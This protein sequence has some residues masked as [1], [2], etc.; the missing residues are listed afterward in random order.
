MFVRCALLALLLA[1][2]ALAAEDSAAPKRGG[3]A[4]AVE[5]GAGGDS[6]DSVTD[7]NLHAGDGLTAMVGGFYRPSTKS[8]L[9]IY[10]LA[11]YDFG[12]VVPVQGGGGDHAYLTSP[13]LEVLANYRFDNKWFVAGGLVG[14]LDPRLTTNEPGREDI[15]FHTAMGATVEAGWSFIGVYYTYVKYDSSR[16]DLDASSVGIRFTMRFRKWRPVH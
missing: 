11:G 9:E 2:P 4:F 1:P 6:L 15:G 5:L 16:V 14:R 7:T 10:A 3:M 8:P 13:V 12:F